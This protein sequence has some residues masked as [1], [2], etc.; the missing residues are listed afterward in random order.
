MLDHHAGQVRRR[1]PLE[2]LKQVALNDARAA[3]ECPRIAGAEGNLNHGYDIL[4]CCQSV[5]IDIRLRSR[6][7][8]LR[9]QRL[10][11]ERNIDSFYDVLNVGDPI[12]DW[13]GMAGTVATNLDSPLGKVRLNCGRAGKR[14]EQTV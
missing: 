2:Q 6:A 3:E 12:T 11:A 7:E 4:D 5:A 1:V 9:R 14:K 10:G 8:R 13:V